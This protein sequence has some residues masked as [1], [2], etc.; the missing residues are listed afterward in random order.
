MCG[1]YHLLATPEVLAEHFGLHRLPTFQA[2]Y[3][4]VPTQKVLC[5]VKLDDGSL[6]SVNLYWGLIP[7]WTKDQ[8]SGPPLFNA[9]LETIGE[10]P[11]FRAAFKHRRCLIAATGFYEWQKLETGKQAF[12]IQRQ[13]Q[14]PFAFAGLW[15][16]WQHDNEVLYSCTLITTAANALMSPIHERMPVILSRNHYHDW[17]ATQTTEDQAINLLNQ[18]D[19][20]TMC[21]VAISNHVNNPRH[22]DAMCL[23]PQNL[24]AC[25]RSPLSE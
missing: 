10:K 11:S 3:N 23:R 12:H 24:D 20:A 7:S 17:L 16:Q 2:S 8:P 13:D 1:R 6:K 15:E 18:A 19:Y 22:D 4:I 5:V 14:K 25:M 21:S 9:R